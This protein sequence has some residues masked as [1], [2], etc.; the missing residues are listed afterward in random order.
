MKQRSTKERRRER[1]EFVYQYRLEMEALDTATRKEIEQFI[2]R[3]ARP[4]L[5]Y[6]VRTYWFDIY[7]ALKIE[8]TKVVNNHK[9]AQQ[10]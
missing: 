5:N 3:V 8:Y 9:I 1:Q 2:N 10:A 6:S 4:Q 7:L